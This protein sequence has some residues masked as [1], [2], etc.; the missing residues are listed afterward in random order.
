MVL[1]VHFVDY[2]KNR[3][4]GLTLLCG[5]LRHFNRRGDGCIYLVHNKKSLAQVLLKQDIFVS[6]LL[7]V[8]GID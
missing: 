5:D 2:I 6:G 3:D 8:I 7:L 1:K 4:Y